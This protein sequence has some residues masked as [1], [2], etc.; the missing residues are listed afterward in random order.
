MIFF[1]S[2]CFRSQWIQPCVKHRITLRAKRM[3]RTVAYITSMLLLC[4]SILVATSLG[5]MVIQND[6]L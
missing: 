2:N 5:D 1:F 6:A 4:N 3:A